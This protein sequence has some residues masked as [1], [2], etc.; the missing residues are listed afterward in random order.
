M[1]FD[2]FIAGLANENKE[3]FS[4]GSSLRAAHFTINGQN[5]TFGA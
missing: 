2:E 4:I 1:N 5:G 3:E